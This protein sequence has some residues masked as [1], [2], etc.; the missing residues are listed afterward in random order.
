[1]VTPLPVLKGQHGSSILLREQPLVLGSWIK[2]PQKEPYPMAVSNTYF[3]GNYKAFF[4]FVVPVLNPRED[5][6]DAFWGL[7]L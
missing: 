2:S 1:M 6:T 7:C 4:V 3:L 5:R